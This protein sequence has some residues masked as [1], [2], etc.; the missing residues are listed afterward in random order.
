MWKCR[1]NP[2]WEKLHERHY[3]D[4]GFSSNAPV[5]RCVP[6]CLF[7][8]RYHQ[9]AF[10]MDG[11]A[12]FA[13]VL[14]QIGPGTVEVTLFPG[15]DLFEYRRKALVALRQD[16][17]EYAVVENIT[18]FEA[19]T[20]DLPLFRSFMKRFGFEIESP[21]KKYHNGE[22]CLLWAYFPEKN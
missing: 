13:L 5:P 11:K 12:I 19:K 4:L 10:V 14:L 8:G 18:R 20:R 21:L 7:H 6:T 22:D 2:N 1:L 17:E 9:Y 3:A 15:K 16:M